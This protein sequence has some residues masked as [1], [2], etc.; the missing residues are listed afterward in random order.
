MKKPFFCF[1][2][3][4]S[5]HPP[6]KKKKQMNFEGIKSNLSTSLHEEAE[7]QAKSGRSLLIDAPCP[8]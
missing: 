3:P 1:G 8:W 6:A 4:I 2:L 5:F 7:T